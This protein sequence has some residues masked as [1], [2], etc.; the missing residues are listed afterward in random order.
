MNKLK[1]LVI[2]LLMI[3]AIGSPVAL[4]VVD[5]VRVAE[6]AT[7]K[8]SQ[9]KMTL[10]VGKS[11]T[12]MISG[13]T[14]KVSWKSGKKTVATVSS[15][16]KVTAKAAGTAKITATVGS[17]KYTCVVT[18]K[19]PVTED[20]QST[21]TP[22]PVKDKDNTTASAVSMEYATGSYLNGIVKLSPP[23]DAD[24]PTGTVTSLN[25]LKERIIYLNN[26][27]ATGEYKISLS[28][29]NLSDTNYIYNVV[30]GNDTML[31]TITYF[32][33]HSTDDTITY[34]VVTVT[35]SLWYELARGFA[36]ETYYDVLKSSTG[37]DAKDIYPIVKDILLNNIQPDMTDFEKEKAIHDYLVNNYS[38]DQELN[39]FTIKG[40]L[41][42][43]EGVCQ[44][45]ADTFQ[46]FMNLMGIQCITQ[47]GV[48]NGGGHAWNIIMLEG[49][50]YN[51]DV[52]WDDPISEK[53]I[54]RYDYFNITDEQLSKDHI[55]APEEGI[56][57]TATK[58]A[59]PDTGN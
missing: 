8:I 39:I 40:L 57:A 34:I 29:F 59:Y 11:K 15:K 5:N 53:D 56:S 16:G 21:P 47:S 42:N 17:R 31:G 49:E 38:Y 26:H 1:S 54:L 10:T 2:I 35:K 27:C 22:I 50:W 6:A 12:L 19:N 43:K 24:A 4:P 20:A 25:Q 58:Y 18:A 14:K 23:A 41:T 52:T 48:A 51:V 7:V 45:Y 33:R 28:G 3:F 55:W 36:D 37:G 46:L 30:F 44:A 13:T 32:V 9:S